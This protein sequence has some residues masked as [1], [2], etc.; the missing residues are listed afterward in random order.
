MGQMPHGTTMTSATTSWIPMAPEMIGRTPR[1]IQWQ[2]GSPHGPNDGRRRQTLRSEEG[3]RAA[4][5]EGKWCRWQW[6]E[7]KGLCE[8]AEV[9]AE[10]E[11]E[12]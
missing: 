6:A 10:A 5:G 8:E 9:E 4:E 12:A 1:P 3:G 2:A 7:D 11:A